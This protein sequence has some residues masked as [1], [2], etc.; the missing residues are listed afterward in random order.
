MRF[1]L[2]FCLCFYC[3][4]CNKQTSVYDNE[5]KKVLCVLEVMSEE[6]NI[7]KCFLSRGPKPL[8]TPNKQASSRDAR[9]ETEDLHA[10][11]LEK[12][13]QEL[14]VMSAPL[15]PLCLAGLAQCPGLL[16]WRRMIIIMMSLR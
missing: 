12:S 8:L 9:R 16:V 3:F 10:A 4:F 13:S 14:H 6:F 15:G 2:V 11:S 1:W 5:A 7:L